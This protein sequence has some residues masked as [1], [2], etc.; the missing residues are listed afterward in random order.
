MTHDLPDYSDVESAARQLNGVASKTP[1]I[2][3][4]F[5]DQQVGVPV[6]VKCEPLQL[7][8]SFKIRGAYNRLSRL[9]EAERTS[10]VVAFSS[11]NHAQ[12]VAR[13]AKLIGMPAT[14]VMPSDTPNVKIEGVRRDGA[15]IIFYDRF[16]ENRE[17]IAQAFSER[18]GAIVVPSYDDPYII[19]GQ[20]TCGLEIV[21]QYPESEPPQALLCC[22]GGGGL[23]A[24]VSLAIHQHWPETK[25]YG[26]EPK[27]FDDT[28]RSL[29]S[30][31]FEINSSTARSICDALLSPSPGK[32]T[33]AINKDHLSGVALVSD[34][35][36]KNAMRFAFLH[37]KTVVEPG[38]VA[39]L[40]ALLSGKVKPIS[41]R[42]IVVVMTGGNVDPEQYADILA[43]TS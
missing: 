43:L 42:A 16:T 20:G 1:L 12:G 8:G 19:S 9:S 15:E 35:E 25:I 13:A 22:V 39:A 3:N 28:A 31:E 7:T 30:G 18:T 29:S 2:R 21:D 6:F 26:V 24:G 27:D 40:A 5:L 10:G 38:G 23:I 32:L 14:I 36:V 33:F 4:A 17:E 11:G 34:D 41:D 37:L